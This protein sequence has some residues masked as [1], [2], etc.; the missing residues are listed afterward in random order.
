MKTLTWSTVLTACWEVAE[1]WDV[2]LKKCMSQRCTFQCV[3]SSSSSLLPWGWVVGSFPL[4]V[5]CPLSLFSRSRQLSIHGLKPLETWAELWSLHLSN[6][7]RYCTAIKILSNLNVEEERKKRAQASEQ[8]WSTGAFRDLHI[9]N[10]QQPQKELAAMRMTSPKA[11]RQQKTGCLN[12]PEDAWDSCR[13]LISVAWT[14][15]V[16][17]IRIGFGK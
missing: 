15:L 7:S 6:S 2:W 9:E 4:G 17:L 1:L 3:T 11:G 14:L 5:N 8:P 12:L 13:P 16:T 10:I